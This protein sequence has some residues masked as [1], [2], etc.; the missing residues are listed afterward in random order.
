VFSNILRGSGEYT[1]VEWAEKGWLSRVR[2]LLP[3]E[4]A[5][6][7][8]P[9]TWIDEEAESSRYDKEK[10][11]FLTFCDAIIR[12]AESGDLQSYTIS[13]YDYKPVFRCSMPGSAEVEAYSEFLSLG[14][15][16]NYQ[17][18]L[19]W[20]Y[21]RQRIPDKCAYKRIQLPVIVREDFKAWLI[22]NGE[23]ALKDDCLLKKWFMDESPPGDGLPSP[24]EARKATVSPFVPLED[25]EQNTQ[26]RREAILSKWLENK[27]RTNPNFDRWYIELTH[28]E[29]WKEL[30]NLSRSIDPDS[31]LFALKSDRTLTEFFS[32]QELCK[33]KPGAK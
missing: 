12:A 14:D 13:L 7:A 27:E 25:K 4:I 24:N 30:D 2:E 19:T 11:D 33:F 9:F 28:K 31:R 26:Q 16:K 6:L 15:Y 3:F 23:W 1:L 20:M 17:T 8:F 10:K 21:A 29:V 18:A 5:F 22:E 32:K